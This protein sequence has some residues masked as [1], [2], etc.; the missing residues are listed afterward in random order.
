MSKRVIGITSIDFLNNRITDPKLSFIKGR[1]DPIIRDTNFTTDT[2][3]QTTWLKFSKML[4]MRWI[5]CFSTR[6]H[7]EWWMRDWATSYPWPL[8]RILPPLHLLT[9]ASSFAR[10]LKRTNSM[11]KTHIDSMKIC[12]DLTLS[13]YQ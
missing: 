7:K 2:N 1:K 3:I 6:L 12:N 10:R 13:K 9:T 11:T 5:A 8:A 4:L